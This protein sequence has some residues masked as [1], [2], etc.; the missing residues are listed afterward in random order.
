M[1]APRLSVIVITKNEAHC[2]AACLDSA[3]FA[4]EL[5]VLDS[6]STDATVEIA[7]A[8]GAQVH[9]SA[10]WPG[11][12]PQ[13]NRAL[14]L[15]R[16]DWVLALDADEI[17][18]P[19]LAAAIQQA[20]SADAGQMTAATQDEVAGYWLKRRSLYCGQL[21]RFGDWRNDRVLRLFRRAAGRFSDDVVHERV[22]CDG[23]TATLQGYLRH[24]SMTSYAEL[25][26]KTERYARLG[27]EKLRAR[28]KGG[29]Y[30]ACTHA[31][32]NWLRGYLLRGGF[33]D[34]RAGWLIAGQNARG[35]FLRY[36]WAGQQTAD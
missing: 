34:G 3:N 18:T 31:A 23:R 19:A 2:I 21:I 29:L 22:I 17:L 35:T 6:G 36:R 9:V 25:R 32:W 30:S 33:L 12:G 7:A 14:A 26:E 4:D 11:F 8:H 15:A 24:D 10:D 16:G 20:V 27:A 13:K 28:G 1:T 5:I